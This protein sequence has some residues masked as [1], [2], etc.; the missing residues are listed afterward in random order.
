MLGDGFIWVRP[1]LLTQIS[2]LH[3]HETEGVLL[4]NMLKYDSI[5]HMSEKS[6]GESSV[7]TSKVGITHMC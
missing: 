7:L 5:Y 2:A 3:L 6:S 1:D 4:E